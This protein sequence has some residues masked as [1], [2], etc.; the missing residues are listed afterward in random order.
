MLGL[1]LPLVLALL[2]NYSP[3]SGL[4]NPENLDSWMAGL[5]TMPLSYVMVLTVYVV[6][7]LAMF[8]ITVLIAVTAMVYGPALGFTLAAS[9]SLLSALVT[10][11]VGVA[12]GR[13]WLRNLIGPRINRVSRRLAERGVLAVVALRA[14]PV[15]PFTVINVAAGISHVSLRDYL[16]GT[17]IGMLPGIATMALLGHQLFALLR[18]PTTEKVLLAAG[19]AALWFAVAI[20]VQAVVTRLQDRR[21]AERLASDGVEGD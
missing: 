16:I 4:T 20:G 5:Q 7:G 18:E 2:W 3:L 10:Y 8:P 15:A 1:A 12:V 17:A 21:Q 6:G 11:G 9:G 19:A 13:R 14:V